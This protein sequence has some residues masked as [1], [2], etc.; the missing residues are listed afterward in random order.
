MKIYGKLS[1]CL[2]MTKKEQ[3][4]KKDPTKKYFYVG[5][6]MDDELGEISTTPEVFNALQIGHYYDFSFCYNTNYEMFQLE[7]CQHVGVSGF[8]R[9]SSNQV[10]EGSAEDV[11]SE[12]VKKTK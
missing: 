9:A 3:P 6:V 8:V 2:V 10:P 12:T 1:D 7:Q 11:S 5:V 4:G